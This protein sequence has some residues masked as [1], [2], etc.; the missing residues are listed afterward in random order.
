MLSTMMDLSSATSPCILVRAS[1]RGSAFRR[2]IRLRSSGSKAVFSSYAR[3]DRVE[4][5]CA[6]RKV[7][8]TSARKAKATRRPKLY[9]EEEQMAAWPMKIPA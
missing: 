7:D 6:A 9:R 1:A 5:P 2:S 8:W 4:A 3:A